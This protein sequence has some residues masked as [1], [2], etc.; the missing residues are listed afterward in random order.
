MPAAPTAKP[1]AGERAL[2]AL[3]Q[4]LHTQRE[5]I[6]T[7]DL[8]ALQSAHAQIHALLNNPGWQR[9]AAKGNSVN[10]LR[11]ALRTA[12]VNAGLAARGEAQAARALAT[13]GVGQAPGVYNAAGAMTR[14]TGPSRGYAA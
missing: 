6:V 3:E 8:G 10:R 11:S 14:R 7:G 9:D 1:G 4:L 5:A 2:S 13:M 12:A